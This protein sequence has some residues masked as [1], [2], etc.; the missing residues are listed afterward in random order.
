M[1]TP[2]WP[3]YRTVTMDDWGASKTAI[4]GTPHAHGKILSVNDDGSSECGI[5]I[6]TPGKWECHV[7]RDEFCH[8]L[9][10]RSTY[11]HESGDVI[12]ITPDT[13]A[14]FPKDWKGVCTVH[15]TIKK[16]YMIR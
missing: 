9:E 5:W 1:T 10:G 16:V 12:E 8:F 3:D 14:F 6:C 13:A 11:V 7:T 2:N 4:S 15:E